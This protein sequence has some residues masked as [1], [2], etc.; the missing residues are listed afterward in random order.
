MPAHRGRTP[1]R[2]RGPHRAGEF[3][4][5]K[6]PAR[7]PSSNEHGKQHESNS[8]PGKQ[9]SVANRFRTQ[10]SGPEVEGAEEFAGE[11]RACLSQPGHGVTPPGGAGQ[12]GGGPGASCALACPL[13]SGYEGLGAAPNS[14][15]LHPPF[16][17]RLFSRGCR[18]PRVRVSSSP[19]LPSCTFIPT[20]CGSLPST[21]GQTLQPQARL[22]PGSS[23][24]PSVTPSFHPRTQMESG[25]RAPS[26]PRGRG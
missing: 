11:G 12:S 22:F 17:V 10:Q 3:P 8:L 7:Q 25:S 19:E 26:S 14:C 16:T 20:L 1:E 9:V 21:T 4:A 5:R 18:W 24:Q 23:G 13:P 2:Q 6:G 15:P